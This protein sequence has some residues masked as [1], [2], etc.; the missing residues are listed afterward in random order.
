MPVWCSATALVK[1]YYQLLAPYDQVYVG[2][3]P[4]YYP[5]TKELADSFDAILNVADEP[6]KIFEPSRPGQAMYWIPLHEQGRWSYAYLY[7][8]K[9]ILDHHFDAGHRI[10]IHC[11]AGAYRSP[12]TAVLWL[13]SR[14]VSPKE[15]SRIADRSNDIHG[16][17]WKLNRNV[18]KHYLEFYNLMRLH[19]DAS[20]GPLLIDGMA[21]THPW[22]HEFMTGYIRKAHLLYH[23]FPTYYRVKSWWRGQKRTLRYFFKQQGIHQMGRGFYDSYRRRDFW[24]NPREAIPADPKECTWFKK[25]TVPRAG[26]NYDS[27]AGSTTPPSNSE[28]CS[29]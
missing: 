25:G 16:G 9:K 14:G 13:E 21:K 8:L 22:S 1:H 4:I 15:A 11:H 7:Q 19:P 29:K 17:S 5:M 23:Y 20:L 27:T 24:A 6:L 12:S 2:G 10:Y 18:P 26:I 3:D 28:P